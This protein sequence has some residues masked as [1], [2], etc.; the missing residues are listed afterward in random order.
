MDFSL[1]NQAFE[2]LQITP[3]PQLILHEAR[4][5]SSAHVPPFPPD[6]PVLLMGVDSQELALQVKTVLLTTYPKEHV[7]FVVESGKKKGERLRE[8]ENYVFSES[9]SL[10]IPALGEGTS[11]ES[12]AEVIARNPP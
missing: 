12:F 2:T 4:T 7:V 11:F 6:M 10:F 5:L 9:T 3:P 1:V 8:L